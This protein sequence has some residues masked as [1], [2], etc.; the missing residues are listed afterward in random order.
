MPPS[1]LPPLYAVWMDQ[2]LAGPIPQESDASCADCAMLAD[3]HHRPSR[4]EVFFNAQ[5][6]CCTY[7]P[8]IPNFLAGRILADRD[9]DFASGRATLEARL[10]AGVVVTPLGLDQ[11]PT[12]LALYEQSSSS[13]FGLSRAVRCPHYM[14]DEGGRCGIWNHRA[15]VCATWYCKYV[16][17]ETG[18]RFW[19]TMHQL[20]TAV[21]TSLA[22]WCVLELDIGAEALRRVFPLPGRPSRSGSIAAPALDG[23]PD[24]AEEK[25]LWGSWAGREGEFYAECAQLVNALDWSDVI[26]IGGPELQVFAHLLREAYDKLTSEEIPERLKVGAVR[27]VK[28]NQDSCCVT[29]YSEYDPLSVPKR[30]VEVLGHF[31]GRLTDQALEAIAAQEGIR[32]SPPLVRKLTDFGVLVPDE[33]LAPQD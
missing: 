7:I 12:F 27:I 11:P 16:R 15:S 6:K 28:M 9:P 21:E 31:D 20:L 26:A 4:T 24:P 17:G 32:L 2:C 3:G 30:L 29:T 33:D 14:P 22:R 25:A 1:P 13:L 23:V 5:T 19:K 18:L 8:A 10:R